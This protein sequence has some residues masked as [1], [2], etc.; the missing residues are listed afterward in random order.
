MVYGLY[1]VYDR[2]AEQAAP[3]FCQANDGL[4]VRACAYMLMDMMPSEREAMRLV[5]LG[6]YETRT[7]HIDLLKTSEEIVLTPPSDEDQSA[8]TRLQQ[9]R[10]RQAKPVAPPPPPPTVLQR[11]FAFGGKK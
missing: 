11:L 9:A 2:T 7:M 3:I 8:Y 5:R 1:T 4:A 6:S 10:I